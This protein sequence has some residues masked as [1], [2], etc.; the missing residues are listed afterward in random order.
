MKQLR[1]PSNLQ[2][3]KSVVQYVA[4][5]VYNAICS[6]GLNSAP[7]LLLLLESKMHE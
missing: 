1:C 4:P 2:L 7:L 3:A 5:G 6:K